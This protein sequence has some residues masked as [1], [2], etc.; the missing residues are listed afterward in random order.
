MKSSEKAHYSYKFK[1]IT[2][3]PLFLRSAILGSIIGG[4]LYIIYAIL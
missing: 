3:S 2:S 1:K 4:I